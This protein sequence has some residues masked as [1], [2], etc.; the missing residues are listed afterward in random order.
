MATN[1]TDSKNNKTL[2]YL[3]NLSFFLYFIIL[4]VERIISV[5]LSIVNNVNLYSDG[6]NGYVYTL[7]FISIIGWLIYTLLFCRDNIKSLFKFNENIT[8]HKICIASGIL[9]LSGMVH[10]EYTI[11]VI[12]FISYGILIIGILLEVIMNNKNT[13][14]KLLSWLSF[15]YLVCLSMAIPVMYHSLIELHVLFHILEAISSFVL[16]IVFTYLLLLIFNDKNDLFLIVSILLVVLLDTP[17][18]V[19]RWNE[20]INFFVLIFEVLSIVVFVIG[21]IYKNVI[22][23]S[24]E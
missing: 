6:F 22:N 2:T 16:V 18:I 15:V 7:I 3:I 20:E 10:S 13:N 17:L 14:N 11:P 12:Q 9:L 8:F 24:K 4:L 5:V 21:F 1:V 19:L 23:K